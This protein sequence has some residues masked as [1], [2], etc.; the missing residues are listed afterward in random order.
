MLAALSLALCGCKL[1]D[2]RTFQRRVAAPDTAA[3]A[4]PALPALP[5]VV[6]GFAFADADWQTPL[7][8]AV[9]AAQL[10]KPDVVFELATPIP[11]DAPQ[12]VQDRFAT[13]GQ[14]DALTVARALQDAGVPSERISIRS[15]CGA[16][17]MNSSYSSCVQKPIT[18]STPARLYQD[19]SNMTISPAAGR[20]GT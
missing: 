19:R 14:T 3:A 11:V 2:Q 5:L 6:V 18:R 13:Q 10:R 8:E 7:R 20:C 4:R 1:V 15:N 12:A 16:S 17:R 9:H